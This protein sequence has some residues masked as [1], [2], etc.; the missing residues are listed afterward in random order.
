GAAGERLRPPWQ[1]QT[2][3][4]HAG[5]PAASS[6]PG[7]NRG[8]GVVRVGLRPMPRIVRTGR[9]PPAALPPK[10]AGRPRALEAIPVER[11]APDAAPLPRC[12]ARQRRGVDRPV[13]ED[14][15]LQVRQYEPAPAPELPT[16]SAADVRRDTGVASRLF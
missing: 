14:E 9:E 6:A 2:K 7:T 3:G 16:A 1:R 5:P 8:S 4:G 10:S 12:A 15:R 11:A 13:P